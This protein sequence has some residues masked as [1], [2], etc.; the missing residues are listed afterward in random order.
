MDKANIDSLRNSLSLIKNNTIKN[1][2][3]K[4]LDKVSSGASTGQAP[5]QT[6]SATID[7]SN[8]TP[9]M[10]AILNTLKIQKHT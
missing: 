5:T 10:K 9:F 1:A 7:D 3:E 4:G 2:I 6:P 8:M